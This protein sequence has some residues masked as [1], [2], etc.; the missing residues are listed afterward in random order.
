M[1]VMSAILPGSSS[2]L[3]TID[4]AQRLVGG[5]ARPELDAHRVRDAA[6]ELD[7]RAVELARALADPGEVRRQVVVAVAAR[8][9]P[10]LRRLVVEV[11]PLVA[12]EELDARELV[13][14]ALA[15]R[16]HEAQRVRELARRALV[17][18]AQRLRGG[19]AAEEREL[20]VLGVVHVGEA[21][22]RERA[23]EVERHRRVAVGDEHVVGVGRR[24]GLGVKSA[25]LTMS[26]K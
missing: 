6:E 18:L 1:R 12:R 15:E 21:A 8:D 22:G 4:E 17:L 25:R 20:P 23:D 16:L 13:D 11:E 9:A 2:G 3:S 5:G 26:P 24:R 10:R 7:V 14:G 19:G